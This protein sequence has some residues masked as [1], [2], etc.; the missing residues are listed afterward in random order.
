MGSVRGHACV[1]ASAWRK[2]SKFELATRRARLKGPENRGLLRGACK[3]GAIRIDRL[4]VS[5]YRCTR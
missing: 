2:D 4:V 1:A 3:F 5:F